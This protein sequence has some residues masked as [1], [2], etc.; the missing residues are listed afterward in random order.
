MRVD[1][2]IVGAGFTGCTLAER[3]AAGLGQT[4]LLAERRSHIGGNAFDH[5]DGHGILVHKYGPHIFHT[6]STMV[7]DY[8]SRFTEWRPYEHRVLGVVEGKKVPIPFNLTSVHALFSP[9]VAERAERRLLEHFGPGARV[10]VL[11]LRESGDPDL[12]ALG[13]YVYQ[14]VFLG[15]T[16][17]QWG[18]RPEELDPAVTARVPIVISRDDRYF[19]DTYQAM[20]RHGYTEM[21][22]R[23]LDHPKIR[24]ATDTDFRDVVDQVQ[25]DRL[26]FT[27]PIDEY[28]GG[29]H[30]PLPYRSLRFEFVTLDQEFHQQVG[31][32]N[33]PNDHE[34]TRVTEQKH[35]T[36]QVSP[37]TT[38][39]V[40]YPQRYEPGRNE[41]Y[42]PI[43]HE[44]NRRRYH[45]Y[46]AEAEK[47][48]GRCLFAGRLGDYA[49]YNMDQ[50][51]ARALTLFHKTIVGGEPVPG[52]PASPAQRHGG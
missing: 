13:D 38:L 23:M 10:P 14:N 48:G 52:A 1:W 32:V 30:G 21:F 50:V 8:L 25:F 11:R 4:V 9:R 45:L 44:D 15:Y 41:P 34:Y 17:K 20:P 40:E 16:L 33:Y 27:G 51:V 46:L 36:G 5:H 3:I 22:R 18:V 42:Y 6:N 12:K 49:Y 29:I 24:V 19:Q 28:F 47:L 35:I 7:W 31:T 43:P 39:A 37:K 2:F 26:V